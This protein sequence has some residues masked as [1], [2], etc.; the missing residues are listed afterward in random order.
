MW[1]SVSNFSQKYKIT[2]NYVRNKKLFVLFY[3][4]CCLYLTTILYFAAPF[5]AI[6]K[7]S[8]QRSEQ[9][10]A[11]SVQ[12][13]EQ[14]TAKNVQRSEQITVKSVQCSEQIFRKSVQRAEQM[15]YKEGEHH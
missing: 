10:T 7:K 15:E 9:I 2:S 5:T 3:E 1:L 12:R 11:K 14:I 13:S 8:V 6:F 4:F